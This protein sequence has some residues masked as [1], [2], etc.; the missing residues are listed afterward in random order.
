MLIIYILHVISYDIWVFV[1]IVNYYLLLDFCK[2]F[3][4]KKL[5]CKWKQTIFSSWLMDTFLYSSEAS[6][7]Q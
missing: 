7:I 2:K 3:S 4:S 6:F 1:A 5:A